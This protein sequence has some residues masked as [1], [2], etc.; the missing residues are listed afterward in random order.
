MPTEASK[1]RE[2]LERFARAGEDRETL[3]R[4]VG[5]VD[6]QIL[7]A[8]P[9]LST[10]ATLVAEL[11][12][13]TRA[14][15]RGFLSMVARENFEVQ[16]APEAFDLARTIARRGFDLPVLLTIYRVGQRSVW[17][18]ITEVLTTQVPESDLRSEV[19]LR[20]WTR[21][22][23][24]LDTAIESMILAFNTEREQWQR[25]SMA[26]RVETVQAILAKRPLDLDASSVALSY[27]LNQLH[28]AFI[29]WVAD[30]APDADVQRLLETA[31]TTI[32]TAI[33]GRRPLSIGS[34]ARTLWCWVATRKPAHGLSPQAVAGLGEHVHVAVGTSSPGVDGFRQSH[35]EARAAHTVA[36][37]R[38]PQP[39][40]TYYVDTE[41]AC[42][43]AG[44][45][46][47]D[48]MKVLVSREL[49][50]LAASD[51]TTNRLRD[52]VRLYLAQS[53][54]ADSTA[55]L[56]NVHPNTVRY[57]IRQAEELLGHPVDERRVYVELALNVVDAFG[58][59]DEWSRQTA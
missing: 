25:G 41:L 8:I 50:G 3:D 15:W 19:L 51:N 52:T 9:E 38:S 5:I 37:R 53:S 22:S 23:E 29:L 36:T 57:R 14:H 20:F 11:H 24:W 31:A 6:A 39:P 49:G 18:Y 47:E 46:G 56:L 54:N 12:G 55:A 58:T 4:L 44:L 16:L 48:G 27:P 13:S 33:G 28:A 21:L 2:W 42:L 30:D 34:G 26:R 7:E 45:M 35:R 32:G 17:T 43:A 1:T 59:V 40:V 10:D